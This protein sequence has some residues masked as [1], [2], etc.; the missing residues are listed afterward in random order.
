[1]KIFRFAAGMAVGYVL[2]SRAG[3]EKYEQIVAGARRF[4]GHPAVVDA[5]AKIRDVVDAGTQAVTAKV[6][7]V[8]DKVTDKVSPAGRPDTAKASTATGAGR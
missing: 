2:G 4:A 8:A 3:R 6:D 5:Q 1:M 7:E